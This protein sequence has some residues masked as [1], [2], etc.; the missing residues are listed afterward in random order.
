MKPDSGSWETC[1]LCGFAYRTRELRCVYRG[2][3]QVKAC[4]SCRAKLIRERL[5]RER[6]KEITGTLMW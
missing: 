5:R 1:E 2:D 3:R 4:P 6:A